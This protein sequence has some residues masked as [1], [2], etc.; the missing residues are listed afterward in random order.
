VDFGSNELKRIRAGYINYRTDGDLTLKITTDEGESYE[1]TIERIDGD[2]L[3]SNRIRLG[4]GMIGRHFQWELTNRNGCDFTIN[5][6][7][8]LPQTLPRKFK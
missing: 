6:M 1:Y 3:H 4:R 5:D 8:L 7:T 2:G